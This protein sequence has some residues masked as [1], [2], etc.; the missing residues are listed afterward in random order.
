MKTSTKNARQAVVIAAIAVSAAV[1]A[2]GTAHA[3]AAPAN[4]D[5]SRLS[6]E[7]LPGVRY[8]SDLSDGSV[9]LSSPI[10]T[11]TTQGG[12]FQVQD[13][14][15]ATVVGEQFAAPVAAAAQVDSA[16]QTPVDTVAA[17][18]PVAGPGDAIDPQERYNRALGTAA[19]QFGLA[20][21]IGTLVGG[22]IGLVSG[23]VLGAFTGGSL[24]IPVSAGT[25]TLPAAAAGCVGGGAMA[26]GF[27]AAAGAALVGIPVG[28]AAA[29][30]FF[31]TINAPQPAVQQPV[32]QQPVPVQQ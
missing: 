19:T 8:T 30:Q 17:V 14:I 22:T 23:C 31:S 25:L 7:I 15:G 5:P 11:L 16:A 20:T 10:G 32:A 28:I 29:S 9:V 13:P 2:A 1:A 18:A 26:G 24:F 12:Q 3:D 27:G 4:T 21:G 6:V